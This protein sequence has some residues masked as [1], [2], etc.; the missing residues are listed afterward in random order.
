MAER[1]VETADLERER[2]ETEQAAWRAEANAELEK[3]KARI[4]ALKA[5]L[6]DS[7]DDRLSIRA[8]YTGVV[9]SLAQRNA[10]NSVE[11]GQELCQIAPLDATPRARVVLAGAGTVAAGRRPAGAAVLRGVSVPALRHASPGR[12]TGS[13]PPP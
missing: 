5:P 8:P 11:A 13:A 12:S 10:G 6:N 2:T 9:I 3:L 7:T 1:R 4:A